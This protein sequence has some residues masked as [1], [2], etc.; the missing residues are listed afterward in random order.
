MGCQKSEILIVPLVVGEPCPGS[1]CREGDDSLT[2]QS[3]ETGDAL[4][5]NQFGFSEKALFVGAWNIRRCIWAG[6]HFVRFSVTLLLEPVAKAFEEIGINY[7]I[8]LV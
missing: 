7:Y 4:R 1:Q 8:G 3:R 6:Y 2:A 5:D